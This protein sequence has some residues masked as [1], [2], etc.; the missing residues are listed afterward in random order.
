M[1]QS[2]L[3]T[4][5]INTLSEV[6]PHLPDGGVQDMAYSTLYAVLANT[7]VVPTVVHSSDLPLM[8]EVKRDD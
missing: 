1:T 8:E 4:L 3:N 6:I 2:E 5:V 7:P